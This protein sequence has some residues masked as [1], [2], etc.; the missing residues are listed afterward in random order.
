MSAVDTAAANAAFAKVA[1]VGLDRVDLS[2]VRAA[3]LM[4]WYGREEPALG[5]AG[6]PHLDEA[7]ALVERL[8]YYNVVPVGRKKSLKRL[9]QKL[10][11]VANPVGKNANFER[12]FQ[13]YLGYLQPLQSREFEATM[14]R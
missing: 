3:A 1:S 7:V 5:S 8:S 6:G 11:A 4:V 10:R 14:R 12:N 9:V 13:R 2:D